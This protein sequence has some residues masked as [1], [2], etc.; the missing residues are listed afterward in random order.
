MDQLGRLEDVADA[1]SFI[2]QA[3]P[4]RAALSRRRRCRAVDATADHEEVEWPVLHSFMVSTYSALAPAG[5]HRKG[6]M[7]FLLKIVI[8]RDCRL[9]HLG[10]GEPLVPAARRRPG[11]SRRRPRRSGARRQP[12]RPSRAGRWSRIRGCAQPVA[13]CLGRRCKMRPSGLPSA[14]L[15][16]CRPVPILPHRNNGL[17]WRKHK[18]F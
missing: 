6:R 3:R 11:P 1:K 2:S 15:T 9:R 4:F 8:F 17:K 12:R 5:S 10:H 7:G 14:G 18:A 16:G 13:L